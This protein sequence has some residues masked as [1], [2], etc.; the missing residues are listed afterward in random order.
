LTN[1]EGGGG[2]PLNWDDIPLLKY[3]SE[4]F[5]RTGAW[6]SIFELEANMTL[7]ELFLLYRACNNETNTQMK[8][9]AASQGADIDFEDDWYDPE[10]I[11]AAG[12]SDIASI[13]FGLGY[14]AI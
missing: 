1:E 6:K 14:E 8:I 11:V 9:M 12:A 3:E 10:P 2:E 7:D 5:V 13:P 4:I